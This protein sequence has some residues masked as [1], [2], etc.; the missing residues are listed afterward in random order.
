M[1][2]LFSSSG[3]RPMEMPVKAARTKASLEMV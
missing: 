1:K 3:N 2:A